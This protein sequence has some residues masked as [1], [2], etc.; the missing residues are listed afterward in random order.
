MVFCLFFCVCFLFVCGAF[1]GGGGS[2]LFLLF[3]V[4]VSSF[5]KLERDNS[6]VVIAWC[7]IGLIT[8]A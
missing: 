8:I 2:F 6:Q 4:V 5:R 3:F 7:V 1:R